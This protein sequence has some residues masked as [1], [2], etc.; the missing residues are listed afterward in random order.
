LRLFNEGRSSDI[1]TVISLRDSLKGPTAP[2]L[3]VDCVGGTVEGL[4]LTPGAAY[5]GSTTSSCRR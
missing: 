5:A 2:T 4:E 1:L 3:A